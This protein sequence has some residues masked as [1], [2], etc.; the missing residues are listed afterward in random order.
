MGLYNGPNMG[1]F[2]R[3]VALSGDHAT[4]KLRD[5]DDDITDSDYSIH[6]NIHLQFTPDQLTVTTDRPRQC[7][8]GHNVT[9]NGTWIRVQ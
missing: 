1:H 8:F 2:V 5:D 4:V 3:T 9:A 7:G 6:C